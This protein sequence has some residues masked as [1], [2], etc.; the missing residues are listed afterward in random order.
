MKIKWLSIVMIVF[1]VMISGCASSDGKWT[2]GEER[3]S[4]NADSAWQQYQ[5]STQNQEKKSSESYWSKEG[6]Y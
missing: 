4:N 5:H 6:R 1:I 3:N 2:K